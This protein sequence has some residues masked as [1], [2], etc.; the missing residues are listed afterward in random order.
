MVWTDWHNE[1]LLQE[2]YLFEPWKYKWG[3][4]QWGQ[5]WERISESL[6][7]HE[8]PRVTV[9]QKSVRNHYILLE[10]EQKNKIREEKA[11]GI[12]P[13]HTP[14]DDS[15]TNIIEQFR[16]RDAED[17]QLDSEKREKAEEETAKAVEMQKA[18]MET[19]SQSK[20]RKGEQEQKKCKRSIG[21]ETVTYLREKAEL[22]V[23][24]KR[25][26]LQLRKAEFDVK[27]IQ[28]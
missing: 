11:S 8:S 13:E 4:K 5:V 24:L 16:E 27:K 22:D 25:E 20:K 18:S 15:M 6:N 23:S 12:A 17:Q 9:N 10:K 28:Q 2:M 21:T 3:S 14:F 7:E 26:E 19:F 1:V